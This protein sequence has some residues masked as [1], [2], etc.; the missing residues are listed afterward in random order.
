M[1]D[2]LIN[3][4]EKEFIYHYSSTHLVLEKILCNMKLKF[5][6]LQELND[7]REYKDLEFTYRSMKNMYY[8]VLEVHQGV[9]DFSKTKFKVACFSKS[10]YFSSQ[11]KKVPNYGYSKAR[12][13]SQ[14]ADKHS[15]V[16][17]VFSKKYFEKQ[18]KKEKR[19]MCSFFGNIEYKGCTFVNPD[20]L[21]VDVDAYQNNQEKYMLDYIKLN[22][23]EIFFIKNLDYKDE[24][25]YR[26]VFYDPKSDLNLID[27]KSSLKGIV[28]G[29]NF[30]QIYMPI[31]EKFADENGLF[32]YQNSWGYGDSFIDQL[33]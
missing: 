10:K 25:E 4:T 20:K 15:G 32:I 24:K 21:S 11:S 2:P 27:I 1:N 8:N 5:S 17:L 13:W 29:D 6:S 12:M 9:N 30:H 16:C 28:L 19:I 31:V 14:Y 3:K 22:Y 7:P 18:I 23:K 33:R 26:I